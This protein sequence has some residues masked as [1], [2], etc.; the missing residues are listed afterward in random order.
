MATIYHLT[1]RDEAD[2]AAGGDYRSASLG[3]EGF[4]HCSYVHQLAKTAQKH[5]AGRADL[6]LFEIDR[7]RV[8]S[9]VIDE[10][11]HGGSDL[12]PHIYG[13]LPMSCVTRIRDF[14]INPDGTFDLPPGLD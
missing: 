7:D 11:L 12:Y 9:D 6:V 14:P 13:E 4:I 3:I 10:N 1:S 5:F 8:P 2:A